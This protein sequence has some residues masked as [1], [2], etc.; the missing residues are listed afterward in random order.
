M[1]ALT[2]LYETIHGHVKKS[3][4]ELSDLLEGLS[5]VKK[6]GLEEEGAVLQ[7]IEQSLVS[8]V[9]DCRFELKLAD[10]RTSTAHENILLEKRKEMSDYLLD[11]LKK[12]PA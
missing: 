9:S 5:G 2:G 12:V 8:L 3:A 10:V 7:K 1:F 11:A 6:D 4:Q